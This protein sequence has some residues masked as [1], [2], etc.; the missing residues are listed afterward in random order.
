MLLS[1]KLGKQ[2]VVLFLQLVQIQKN[3]DVCI[4]LVLH[5]LNGK[6]LVLHKDLTKDIVVETDLLVGLFHFL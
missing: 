6:F 2:L 3:I 1:D 4:K 5:I